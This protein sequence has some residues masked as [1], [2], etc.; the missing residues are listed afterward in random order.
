MEIIPNVHHIAGVMAN[1]YLILDA[2]GLTL[3]D[4]GMPGS[5]KKI[6]QYVRDLG[7]APNDLRRILI[8]HADVDHVGSLAALKAASGA[9]VYTSAIEAEAIAAGSPSRTFQRGGLRKWLF[10][11]MGRFFKFQPMQVDEIL[12]DGD[13]L[14]ILGGLRVVSTPRAHPRTRFV[15][16]AFGWRFVRGRLADCP[17]RRTARLAPWLHLGSCK[18]G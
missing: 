2:D 13:M 5:A 3:I 6:L 17:E 15:I 9:R 12:R 8:T 18:G 1:P 14:P 10:S 4:R 7:H 11:L 16:R